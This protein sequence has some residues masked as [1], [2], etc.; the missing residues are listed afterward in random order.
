MTH[1]LRG[2]TTENDA[3]ANRAMS[4]SAASLR[5]L[6]DLERAASRVDRAV[7]GASAVGDA[8]VRI[9]AVTVAGDRAID[10]GADAEPAA[11]A[12]GAAAATAT[13]TRLLGEQLRASGGKDE[14]QG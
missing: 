10:R 9:P 8:G 2:R 6:G 5:G 1:P 11:R 13:A 7:R 3:C 14:T 12:T 4:R